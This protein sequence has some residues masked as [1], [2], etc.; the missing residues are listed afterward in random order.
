MSSGQGAILGQQWGVAN[1]CNERHEPNVMEGWGAR[2][3]KG[4]RAPVALK[5]AL[6]VYAGPMR[7]D[8]P[9][10]GAGCRWAIL[11]NFDAPAVYELRANRADWD[12]LHEIASPFNIFSIE[13]CVEVWEG[14]RVFVA[15]FVVQVCTPGT[16]VSNTSAALTLQTFWRWAPGREG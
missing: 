2:V 14:A 3:L 13:V 7:D 1:A 9:D 5:G 16:A 4:T 6:E 10:V 15:R 11:R 12:D 8:G